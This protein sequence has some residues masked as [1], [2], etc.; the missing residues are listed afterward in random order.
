MIK[1]IPALI[2]LTIVIIGA[3]LLIFTLKLPHDTYLWRETQNLGHTPLFGIV[4]ISIL[5][6]LTAVRGENNHNRWI[7]YLLAFSGASIL[8]AAVEIAQIWTPGDADLVDFLRDLAGIIS[9]LGLY[10]LVDTRVKS[11]NSRP[12]RKF[13]ILTGSVLVL[14]AALYQVTWLSISYYERNR[15]FP[16]LIDF[17][18]PWENSFLKTRNAA[19]KQVDNSFDWPQSHGRKIARLTFFQANYPTFFIE[20]PF[21]DWSDFDTLSFGVYSTQDTAVKLTITIEDSEHNMKFEDRFNYNF[22]VLPG[23]NSIDIPLS[24]IENAPAR[25]TMAMN[26]IRAI[27]IFAYKPAASFSVYFDN[28]RLR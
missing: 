21:P 16:R 26:A 7:D 19:W 20:E 13:L 15:F 28:F 5:G 11:L 24:A 9:F 18:S 8:G 10:L 2:I 1:K 17:E 4:A 6:I 25:R 14:C 3:I 23:P 22:K 27:H 12:R